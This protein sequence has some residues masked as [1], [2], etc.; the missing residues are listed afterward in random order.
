MR[1]I[2][3]VLAGFFD[4]ISDNWLHG[5]VLWTAAYV[6]GWEAAQERL[7][8]A[9]PEQ[10]LLPRS[11]PGRRSRTT[12]AVL[13]VTALLFAATVGSWHRYTWPMTAAIVVVA[14]AGLAVGWRGP[15]T[16]PTPAPAL[17]R[18]GSRLW[19]GLA[20]AAG[21]WEL[22]ALSRQPSLTQGSYAH[23]TVSV[24]MDSVLSTHAGR[25]L[26]VLAWLALGWFLLDATKVIPRSRSASPVTG[27]TDDLA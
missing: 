9:P 13:V 20:V 18:V 27:G 8:A 10:P 22:F 25:S 19:V 17:D 4:G 6:V 12:S 5:L 21:L 7:G 16:A 11:A 15:L 26:V 24:L 3:L 23:P 14:I 1:V 2:V